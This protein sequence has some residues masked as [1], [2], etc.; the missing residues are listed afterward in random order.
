MGAEL[1]YRLWAVHSTFQ[2]SLPSSTSRGQRSYIYI[3]PPAR[4]MSLAS[5][6][7]RSQTHMHTSYVTTHLQHSYINLT[8]RYST[9]LLLFGGKRRIPLPTHALARLHTWAN[10]VCKHRNGA[11]LKLPCNELLVWTGE[12]SMLLDEDVPT[13]PHTKIQ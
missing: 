8:P 7:C 10:R 3:I 1:K 13:H 5:H 11:P 9:L 2:N 6:L 4:T 12:H